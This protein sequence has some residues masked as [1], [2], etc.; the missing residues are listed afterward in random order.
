MKKQGGHYRQAGPEQIGVIEGADLADVAADQ[1][2][3]SDADIPR[4]QIGRSSGSPLIV[5]RQIDKQGIEGREHRPKCHPQ[6]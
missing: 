4:S 5:R 2:T 3:Y 6:Q 1:Q